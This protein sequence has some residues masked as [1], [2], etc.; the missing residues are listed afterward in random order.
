MPFLNNLI[1]LS[2]GVQLAVFLVIVGLVLVFMK[3][4]TLEAEVKRLEREQ[5]QYV[6]VEDYMETLNNILDERLDQ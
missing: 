6:T 2:Q 5:T 3:C 4:A 1:F